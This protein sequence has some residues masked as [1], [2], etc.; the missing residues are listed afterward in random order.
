MLWKLQHA[1]VNDKKILNEYKMLHL[2]FVNALYL[3]H[4]HIA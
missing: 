2:F 3:K 4:V 1:L